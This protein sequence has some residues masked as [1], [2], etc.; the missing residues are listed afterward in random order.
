MQ[1]A[2]ILLKRPLS[3]TISRKEY[4]MKD[5]NQPRLK[6]PK[7]LC[8]Y[9][10]PVFILFKKHYYVRKHS[11]DDYRTTFASTKI[12]QSLDFEKHSTQK[13][14]ECLLQLD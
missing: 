7:P 14:Q 11:F 4:V 2:E 12:Y 9:F 3:P 1:Q 8:Q 6:N 10:V 5:E 13:L